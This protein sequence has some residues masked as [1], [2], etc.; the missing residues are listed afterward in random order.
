MAIFS[1]LL[2]PTFQSRW[3]EKEKTL[4]RW[5]GSYFFSIFWAFNSNWALKAKCRP[6]TNTRP[7]PWSLA[8]LAMNDV[9][10]WFCI[11]KSK[12]VL[13][14]KASVEIDLS[15][16]FLSIKCH[17]LTQFFL[18]ICLQIFDEASAQEQQQ[19][20]VENNFQFLSTNKKWKMT[21]PFWEE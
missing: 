19:T 1:F 21:F 13:N 7:L 16:I 5:N 9:F 3:N 6:I 8:S 18:N 20:F 10:T 2:N 11:H 12:I 14:R 15:I 4:E 17:L